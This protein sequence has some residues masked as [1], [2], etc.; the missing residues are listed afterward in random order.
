LTDHSS[1]PVNVLVIIAG[2]VLAISGYIF[3]PEA[4]WESIVSVSNKSPGS[5]SGVYLE[6]LKSDSAGF[7][8]LQRKIHGEA[9]LVLIGSS[10]LSHDDLPHIPYHF[11]NELSPGSCVAFGK[12]GFQCAAILNVLAAAGIDSN[13]A[14]VSIILSPGW[15]EGKSAAGTAPAVMLDF[16]PPS[17]E[18]Q[19]NRISS[20]PPAGRFWYRNAGQFSRSTTAQQLLS[21]KFSQSRSVMN[22]ILYSPLVKLSELY[23]K[24]FYKNSDSL[25]LYRRIFSGINFTGWDSLMNIAIKK[26]F[27]SSE[28]NTLGINDVYYEEYLRG[29]P[30]RKINPPNFMNNDELDDFLDLLVFLRKKRV[31]ASF[32][33]Q[34]LHPVVYTNLESMQFLM[35]KIEH[36]ISQ[37]KFPYLNLMPGGSSSYRAGILDDI[38]HLGDAGW[39]KIDSFLVANHYHAN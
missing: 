32:V 33:M 8:W 4:I 6:D 13:S 10:E 9:Q 30:H 5:F 28:G 39:I 21:F 24:Q 12:A 15:F 35:T 29:K 11:L 1:Y 20:F 14:G 37:A 34:P 16:F 25:I 27:L 2:V 26:Q 31:K 18:A 23:I 38:M 36:E 3:L 17:V 7:N 22:E 19:A